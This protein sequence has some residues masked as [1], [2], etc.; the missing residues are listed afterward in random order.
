[1]ALF[2]VAA[3]AADGGKLGATVFSA[4]VSCVYFDKSRAVICVG[5][6]VV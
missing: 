3:A 6:D 5:V 2:A 1:M 4:S